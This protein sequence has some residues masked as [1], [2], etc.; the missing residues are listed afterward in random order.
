MISAM[1]VL[2]AET[3]PATLATS[4]RFYLL[5]IVHSLI[6]SFERV[7]SSTAWPH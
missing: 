7:L 1:T 5:I 3:R 6:L 4:D 2:R